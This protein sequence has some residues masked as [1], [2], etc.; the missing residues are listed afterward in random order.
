M[1]MR[2][3]KKYVILIT[4]FLCAVQLITAQQR[5]DP[6]VEV[7][8]DFEAKLMEIHKPKLIP[9]YS[10]SLNRFNLQFDYI[11]FNTPYTDLYEFTPI[12]VN[13]MKRE[14]EPK[15]P[16]LYLKLGAMYPTTPDAD[17]YIQHGFKN[18]LSLYAFGNHDSF[19]GE[20]EIIK[21]D[22]DNYVI[23]GDNRVIADRMDNRFGL[24]GSYTWSKGIVEMGG[25]Y[26][27]RSYMYH[28]I[29]DKSF[30]DNMLAEF[31]DRSYMKGNR[32]NLFNSL[33][34]KASVASTNSGDAFN[35]LIE[36]GYN[37]LDFEVPYMVTQN[38]LKLSENDISVRAAVSHRF[39]HKHLIGLDFKV[40]AL[41][42]KELGEGNNV[43]Y[44]EILP[45]YN[46]NADRFSAQLGLNIALK[47][48]MDESAVFYNN[49]INNIS[50]DLK[51]SY[52]LVRDNLWVYG[53]VG[54]GNKL[55][56]YSSILT[57]NPWV[58]TYSDLDF[59]TIA[60][61][62]EVGFRGKT[63]GRFSYN[64]HGR[65]ENIKNDLL[66]TSYNALVTPYMSTFYSD[67]D[68]ISA[69]IQLL[70]KSRDVEAGVDFTYQHY[71]SSSKYERYNRP[72][73]LL[74]A[75]VRYNWN[76][77]VILDINA[78]YRSSAQGNDID[79]WDYGVAVMPQGTYTKIPAFLDLGASFTYVINQKLSI[80]VEAS[81]ILNSNIQYYSK[82]FEPGL[83]IGGGIF[84]KL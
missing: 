34:V 39:A 54:G 52:E 59:T 43:S 58:S 61:S 6:T 74:D 19:W 46:Y 25:F 82:Y 81:N 28:G 7:R 9:T 44:I 64:I 84:L 36:V 4:L 50:P 48:A 72:N 38:P 56:T 67:F 24:G 73:A 8:R 15:Y 45:H 14:G 68:R 11:I 26:R 22:S 16:I 20:S 3:I 12:E 60:L 1:I 47:G 41:S 76:E 70:W 49:K 51:A 10:D 13:P 17:L 35:Y 71:A 2:I 27:N 65:Y 63:S 33:G 30:S 21:L 75:F 29:L 53:E 55:N 69:G 83:R 79:T 23:K 40:N 42:Y 78:K 5:I 77:R 57:D 66:Y 62:A 18:G 37:L 31:K 80:Y 32:S